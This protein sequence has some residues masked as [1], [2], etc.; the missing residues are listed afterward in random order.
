MDQWAVTLLGDNGV[1]KT[2]LALRIY[3]P[4]IEDHYGK[5]LYVDNRVCLVE[6]IDPA[7]Q[8]EWGFR[9]SWVQRGQAALLVYSI[10]SRATF[11]GLESF[12]HIVKRIK[13]GDAILILVGN[14]CDLE[15]RREVSQEEG[16]ALALQLGCKFIET[17]AKTG[18]NVDW[19]V[20]ILV[21]TLRG[22]AQPVAPAETK[23]KPT[24]SK[25]SCII[26]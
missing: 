24:K 10:A 21:R 18:H 17:S 1:G 14:K 20:A 6:V 3:D 7:L 13:G 5:Q 22:P 9:D 15:A 4:T 8:E 12:R 23:S 16:A 11:D 25:R 26:L 2:S 19:A